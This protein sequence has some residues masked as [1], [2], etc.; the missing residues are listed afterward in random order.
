MSSLLKA[1]LFLLSIVLGRIP[2][3]YGQ[4]DPYIFRN[5]NTAFGLAWL[6]INAALRLK[7]PIRV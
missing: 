5:I 2:P 7:L 4:D 6:L 3:G 1:M